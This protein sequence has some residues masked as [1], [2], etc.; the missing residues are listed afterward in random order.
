MAPSEA[1]LR[2][3]RVLVTGAGGL[4]GGALC[5]ALARR[6]HAVTALLRRRQPRDVAAPGDAPAFGAVRPLRG[7]VAAPDLGLEGVTRLAGQLDLVVHCAALTGF[8][9]A[10]EAYRRVNVGGTARVLALDL[11]TLHVGTAF[12]CGDGDGAVAEAPV[13]AARFNNGYEASKAEAEALVWAARRAGR[14]VAV[15]RPSVVV[16]RWAD[17]ATPSFGAVYQLIRLAAE[18]RVRVLPAAPGASLDLVPLDHVV[19]GLTDIAECLAERMG[20]ADGRVFH[21]A[22]GRPVP[23]AAL[24]ALTD[25]FPACRAPRLVPPGHD[26]SGLGPRERWMQEQVVAAYAAYLRPSPRF[27]TGNLLALSG[28][29]CPPVDAAFLHRLI[30]FAV[31]AGYLPGARP[32]AP[33]QRTSG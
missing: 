27:A 11:P 31:E 26:L 29:R 13:P 9:L 10:D 28:R 14:T 7:D 17:G 3:L 12:V 22:S 32:G 1:A 25:A 33:A 5:D 21:L 18:G 24:T 2:S 6:G 20:E 4:I 16:G 19:G 23:L 8:R 30:G 15:A